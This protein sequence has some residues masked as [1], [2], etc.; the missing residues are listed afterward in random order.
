MMVR[1]APV[2]AVAGVMLGALSGAARAESPVVVLGVDG[3]LAERLRAALPDRDPPKSRF[4]AQRLADEAGDVL[5]AAL[6]EEGYYGA[7]AQSE[8]TEAPLT[9]RV[10]VTPGVLFRIQRVETQFVGAPPSPSV[11]AAVSDALSSLKIGSA[12]DARAVL[13][14]EANA[15]EM[16]RRLGYAQAAPGERDALV[17]HADSGMYLTFVF[18]AGPAV[19]FGAL[20]V[21][22]P[23]FLRDDYVQRLSQIEPGAVYRPEPLK[24]LR[25]DLLRTGVF[26]SVR[27]DLDDRNH[28]SGARDVLISLEPAKP[29]VSEFGASYSTAEGVGVEASWAQRNFSGRADTLTLSTILSE[30]QQQIAAELSLPNGGGR[31]RDWLLGVALE[32][33]TTGPFERT[34]LRASAA[35]QASARRELGVSLGATLSADTFSSVGGVDQ[36]IVLSGYIDVRRDDT[37]TP[38]DAREG[39]ILE[40]R[41]E[42]SISGGESTTG[43]VRATAQARGY[44]SLDKERDWTIAGR[45]N[46]GWVEAVF[47]DDQA[48]PPDRRFYAGGGGSVRGYA[49]NSIFPE[50]TGTEAP[51]GRALLE[52][53]F[54]LRGRFT[55]SIGGVAFVDGGAAA[56]EIGELSDLRW[57]AGIGFRYDLG[58]GP[59]RVDVATPLDKRP[60]DADVSIYVSIGQA[61]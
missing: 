33:D 3:D 1:V 2:L 51:G 58:F 47:G 34:G 20:K 24:E 15:I 38:L 14:A 17:D 22:P 19:T 35:Q 21:L 25:R 32:R 26:S 9:A 16:L 49:Y 41:L 36:A 55:E 30:Q 27:V 43:F 29:H 23:D 54:E 61:F 50:R 28:E 46:V 4:E 42:P 59:L 44:L 39:A 6:N 40:A 18:D 12:A 45:A 52:T 8:I 11:Q 37:D 10:I 13:Q 57:G 53:S 31:G 5:I 7:D 56:N 48:I 60:G